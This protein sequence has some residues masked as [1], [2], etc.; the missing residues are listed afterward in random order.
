MKALYKHKKS[1][2]IFAIETDDKGDVLSTAGPL[3]IKDLDPAKLDYD[4]YF[5]NEVKAKIKDFILLSK[6]D[7]LDL[8]HKNGFVIQS[9]Q[10]RL[11]E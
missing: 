9:S 11:F 8:L 5:K 2:D 7:Y 4:N 3:L 6:A 1:G 10:K